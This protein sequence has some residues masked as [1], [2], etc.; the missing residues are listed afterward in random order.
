M[1]YKGPERRQYAQLPEEE[2]ERLAIRA[3]ELALQDIY[4]AVGKSVISKIMWVLGA[5]S[6]A[7]AAWLH[8]K[9]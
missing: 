6:A 3:K 8:F 2:F 9:P 4:I 5:A 1:I 7:V